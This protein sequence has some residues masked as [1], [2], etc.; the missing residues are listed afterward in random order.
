MSNTVK[1]SKAATAAAKAPRNVNG[2]AKAP[3]A[4]AKAKAKAKNGA[5]AMNDKAL[6]RAIASANKKLPNVTLDSARA[7]YANAAYR[8]DGSCVTYA[9]ALN[10]RFGKVLT[11]H[12]VHWSDV[13]ASKNAK[14]DGSNYQPLWKAIDAERVSLFTLLQGKHSNPAQVWKRARDK[15]FTIACPNQQRDRDHVVLASKAEK[16]LKA[17]YKAFMKETMPS[18]L[19]LKITDDIGRMLIKHFKIDLS[20]LE[21]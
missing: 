7:A 6:A 1:G 18:E 20:T 10:E 9:M 21:A 14:A 2:G 12:R 3:K 4:N 19:D 11:D 15:A 5:K 17:M 16:S 13:W 8:E